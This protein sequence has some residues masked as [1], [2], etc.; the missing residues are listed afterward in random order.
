MVNVGK[1]KQRLR[2]RKSKA[3]ADS[4]CA[5]IGLNKLESGQEHSESVSGGEGREGRR[6][7]R[8]GLCRTSGFQ[9]GERMD[10]DG[11]VSAGLPDCRIAVSQ[12]GS[13]CGVG[14]VRG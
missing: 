5:W 13:G 14:R 8:A 6:P 2:A 11:V 9:R 7:D 4:R 1:A 3:K 10:G 12:D